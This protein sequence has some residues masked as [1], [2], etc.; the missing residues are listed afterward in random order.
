M[1]NNPFFEVLQNKDFTKIWSSQILSQVTI[2]LINFVIVLRIF[3]TTH[4][5]VA[6]SLVWIFYAIPALLVGPF[7]GT[8]V[9]LVEKKKVLI[10][11][12]FIEAGV[13]LL[14]LLIRQKVWSLYSLIFVYSLVNQFYV[15]AEGSTLTKVVSK[16]LLA[17]ANT[18]FIFTMYGTFLVGMGFAGSIIRFTGRSSPFIIGACLLLVASIVVS[19]L[20][21]ISKEKNE[22]IEGFND[23]WGKVTEGY[24]FVR[25]KR[26]VLY[27][28]GLLV[29]AN[30]FVS[31][32]A[33]LS[34]IVATEIL[35]IGLLDVG[36]VMVLPVG[37][38][39]IMGAIWVV[40]SLRHI[41]KKRVITFGLS[42]LSLCLLFIAFVLPNMNF[43]RI[44]ISMLSAFLIGVGI[45]SLFIP[46]QTLMQEKTPEEFRG[47]VF[48]LLGFLFTM[49]SVLPVLLSATI[50]DNLGIKWI[51][52]LLAAILAGLA[53]YS[54]REPYLIQ[55]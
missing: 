50:A 29:L 37:L 45:V 52:L 23:F 17:P 30:I 25:R 1:K 40:L 8:I 41:R 43:G 55:S 27:P 11:T 10:W 19:F 44:P 35:R 32:F 36:W 54:R 28:L 53:I 49:A 26:E 39:A 14:Y 24:E 15:P 48:G 51:I 34:P 2:N 38:G 42:L 5:V 13:V 6:V 31:I 16:R 33:V 46:A 9:D 47:R 12:T 18:L 20:P 3:E 7:S 21:R 22:K 4:S